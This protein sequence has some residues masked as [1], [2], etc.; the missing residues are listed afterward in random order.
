MGKPSLSTGAHFVRKKLRG[1]FAW[2][3]YAWRGGPQVLKSEG[4]TRPRLSTATLK[5]IVTAQESRAAPEQVTLRSLIRAYRSFD[6]NRPSS[7][8]WS[9]LA[10]T[11]KK[12]WGSA[13]D[14]IEEKWGEVPLTV[15]NDPRMKAKVVDWRDSRAATPRAADIGVTVLKALLKFGTLRGKVLTNVASDIPALYQGGDRAEIIWTDDEI[16]RFA[17]KAVEIGTTAASDGLRLAALT[18]LRR[19]DLV[20]LTWPQVGDAAI[21]KKALKR[22]R[23]KRRHATIPRVP[24]L[25]LLLEELKGR[26]RQA[27]VETVL[28]DDD[29]ARWSPDRLTKA[30]NRVRDLLDIAFID[31]ETG[32]R[33][34]KH[35]HDARGTFVTKLITS[36]QCNDQEVADVMGWS[37][38]QVSHIRRVYVDQAAVVVAIGKRRNRAV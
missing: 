6:P 5:M 23:G 3:V 25:D 35:L 7:P 12:T 8:E 26:S 37:P 13:L 34:K 11:T 17:A 14:R 10:A 29:G 9:R 22:S 24:Q 1:G 31:S 32:V 21:G 2:Y 4:P 28:V 20:T 38:Q 19:E 15:F 30:V 16:A 33:R 36:K 27:G 18:G